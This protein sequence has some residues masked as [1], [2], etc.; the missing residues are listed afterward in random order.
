MKQT[1]WIAY[2]P[3]QLRLDGP[4][5]CSIRGTETAGNSAK[6]SGGQGGEVAVPTSGGDAGLG[7][8]GLLRASG[9][10]AESPS[11][12]SLMPSARC[13]DTAACVEPSS[14]ASSLTVSRRSRSPRRRSAS[15][16][17]G[18]RRRR[19][20]TVPQHPRR[21]GMPEPVR[22]EIQASPLPQPHN[23][24]INS[25]IGHRMADPAAPEIDKDIVV[26]QIAVFNMQIVRIQAQQLRADR[27]RP[28][29]ARAPFS[30]MRATTLTSQ[31]ATARSSWRSPSTSPIRIP[32]SKS[33][34][35]NRRS[36]SLSWFLPVRRRR[37]PLGGPACVLECVASV[38]F[39]KAALWLQERSRGRSEQVPCL[40][41]TK[42]VDARFRGW[43][44]RRKTL[45]ALGFV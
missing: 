44:S 17:A 15:F 8:E 42:R 41:A 39:P 10:C 36:L 19:G 7:L 34:A 25:P 5:Q 45:P 40:I 11:R 2:K 29:L 26:V 43:H 24:V 23:Q 20:G 22:V 9:S 27:D 38:R 4:V 18:P 16:P 3:S 31:S 14:S 1:I 6:G 37:P 33:T 32:V 13:W 35:N 12:M 21:G 28:V 30:L